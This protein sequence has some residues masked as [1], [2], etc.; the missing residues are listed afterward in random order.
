MMPFRPTVAVEDCT[1]KMLRIHPSL[2]H[3]S[4]AYMYSFCAYKSMLFPMVLSLGRE[5]RRDQV[6]DLSLS[7]FSHDVYLKSI[8]NHERCSSHLYVAS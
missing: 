3:S 2:T 4:R 8:E 7:E 6:F 5:K 1:A